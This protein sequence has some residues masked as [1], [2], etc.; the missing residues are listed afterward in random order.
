M[1]SRLLDLGLPSQPQLRLWLTNKTSH[2]SPYMTLSHCWAQLQI[3]RLETT[4]LQSLCEGITLSELPKTFQDAIKFTRASGVRYLWIDSLC[5]VQDA[6]SDWQTE[7]A[8]MGDVYKNAI[9]NIA[10]TA[11]PDGRF[12]CFFE[13]DPELVVPCRVHSKSF[14][15]QGSDCDLFELVPNAI[16]APNVDNAPLNSRS[17]VMQERFLS[18]RIVHCGKNQLFWECRELVSMTFTAL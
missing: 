10:A 11:A 6:I 17:W 3:K 15:K 2:R 4:N 5:I 14:P 1:P 9:C 8:V 13:R 7:S 16:W 12:G 18:P